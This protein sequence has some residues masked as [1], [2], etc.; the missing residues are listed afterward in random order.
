MKYLQ[1]KINKVIKIDIIR[2]TNYYKKVTFTYK[3]VIIF[4][5][6]Y[7]QIAIINCNKYN[8][9]IVFL[10]KQEKRNRTP[11]HFWHMTNKTR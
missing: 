1:L 6:Y 9:E 11:P 10:T 8:I 7:L 5:F 3:T 2:A 4:C